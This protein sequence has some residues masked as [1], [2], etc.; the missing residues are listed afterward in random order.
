MSVP[1]RL[2]FSRAEK[3]LR[4]DYEG[5]QSL[6]IPFE[7]LRVE[8]PSAEVQ[9]H[10]GDKP[11]PVTGKAGVGVTSAEHVGQYAIRIVFDDG[12]ESGYFTWEFL[13]DLGRNRDAIFA[14]YKARVAEF[15]GLQA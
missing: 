2:I 11:P 8:S 1:T 5:E 10:G 15:T 13:S 6:E 3:L 4:L 12:H 14:G 7:L 9:G